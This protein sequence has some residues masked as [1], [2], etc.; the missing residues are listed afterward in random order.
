M[1]KKN[2]SN[3]LLSI[4]VTVLVHF[5]CMSNQDVKL[6]AMNKAVSTELLLQHVLELSQQVNV[7]VLGKTFLH[8]SKEL[9]LNIPAIGKKTH[10][11][12]CMH[13]LV[14][15]NMTV[16]FFCHLLFADFN[17]KV[18]SFVQISVQWHGTCSQYVNSAYLS[19]S[20]PTNRYSGTRIPCFFTTNTTAESDAN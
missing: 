8:I 17:T 16:A 3:I 19:Y 7:Y 1:T 13:C 14:N 11:C 2:T 15:K 12:V 20:L 18:N 5:W 9:C 6:L 10:V 4:F